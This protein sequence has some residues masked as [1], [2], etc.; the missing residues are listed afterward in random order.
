MSSPPGAGPGRAGGA[1]QRSE[2]RLR[3]DPASQ[4]CT[5]VSQLPSLESF[6]IQ[7]SGGPGEKSQ[8]WFDP[9]FVMWGLSRRH[10]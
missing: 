8:I 3:P 1:G 5:T 2:E 9:Y 7:P 4:A 6:L 10:Y